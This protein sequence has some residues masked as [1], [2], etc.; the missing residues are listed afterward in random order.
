MVHVGRLQ[1]LCKKKR[2]DSGSRRK[3]FKLAFHSF[4]SGSRRQWSVDRADGTMPPNVATLP[5]YDDMAP[6]AYYES[7][8]P[9]RNAREKRVRKRVDGR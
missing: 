8:L 7:L 6:Y 1:I 2:A 3:K 9:P 5:V 4:R